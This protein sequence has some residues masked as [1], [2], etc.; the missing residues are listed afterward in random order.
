MRKAVLALGV[1]LIVSLPAAGFSQWFKEIEIK[2]DP[3]AKGQK[4]Y[5]VKFSPEKTHDCEKIVFECAYHQEFPWEDYRGR[6]YTK[7]HEPVAF[8]YRRL[9]VKFVNELDNYVSFRVPINLALLEEA[10]GPRVF[11]KGYPVAIPR[12]RITG[13]ADGKKIWSY[14][15]KTDAKHAS[16]ELQLQAASQTDEPGT[17][18]QS[19]AKEKTE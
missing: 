1:G 5:T 14:E 15:L 16:D 3:E 18:R 17:N 6:K 13:F 2:S 9:D 19:S 4:D 10:Y 7:I 11:N 12:M 8:T